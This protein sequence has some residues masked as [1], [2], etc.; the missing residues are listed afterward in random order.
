MMAVRVLKMILCVTVFVVL[1]VCVLESNTHLS[2]SIS[3]R[4]KHLPF[5]YG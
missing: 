1:L 3:F 4:K 5:S 2:L